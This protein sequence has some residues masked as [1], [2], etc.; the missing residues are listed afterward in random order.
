MSRER[1][2]PGTVGPVATVPLGRLLGDDTDTEQ[3]I[4]APVSD[5]GEQL[6]YPKSIKVGQ[7]VKIRAEAFGPTQTYVPSRWRGLARVADVDGKLTMVRRWRP[8]RAAAEAATRKAGLDLLAEQERARLAAVEAA[9]A[10]EQGDVTTTVAELLDAAVRTPEFLKLAPKSRQDYVYAAEQVK[11]YP[12]ARMLPRDVDV[13]AVREFLGQYGTDHGRGGAKHARAILARAFDLAVG[14]RALRVPVNCVRGAGGIPDVVVKDDGLD[15]RAAPTDGEVAALLSALTR[16]PRAR[17]QYPGTA[18]RKARHGQGGSPT[19]GLDLADLVTVLFACGLRLSEAAGLRVCDFDTD[20]RV[21]TVAGTAS[22]TAGN[23][24]VRSD[25]TKTRG[26]ART[27]PLAP[28]AYGALLRRVRRFGMDLTSELPLFGSPQAPDRFR[29]MRNLTRALGDAFDRHGVTF[30]RS[31]LGRKWR[32]TSLIDRGI[33]LGKVADLVGH[34][35]IETT[36][37]YVGRGR[38]HD[39]DVLAAL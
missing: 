21:L 23:G 27:V 37:G 33:P 11:D 36:L 19:N 31:H 9:A 26:S 16:D 6:P 10:A 1:I 24:T 30:G 18:R 32:V 22:T 17:A 14:T 7:P 35:K 28:W 3:V 20:L 8:T 39:A 34:S 4:P 25:R 2:T 38:Q 12:V 29:D 13:A 5:Q 15:H